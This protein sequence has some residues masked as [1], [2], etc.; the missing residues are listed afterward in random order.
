M[1]IRAFYGPINTLFVRTSLNPQCDRGPP[2]VAEGECF[3]GAAK[4]A[5][6]PFLAIKARQSKGYLLED[7]HTK[8]V[9]PRNY[10]LPTPHLY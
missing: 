10:M 1:S 7:M 3:A 2:D 4:A 6:P 9:I 8:R 5:Q